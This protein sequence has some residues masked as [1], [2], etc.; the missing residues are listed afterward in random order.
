MDKAIWIIL[1]VLAGAMLPIQAGLNTKVGKEI[2][3]PVWASLIS[4][5]VGAIAL[6]I[7]VAVTKTNI[8]LSGFKTVPAYAWSAGALGAFYV[9]VVIL[10]YPKLGPALTFG[11]IVTGQL[12][13]SLIMDHFNILVHQ[14][15]TINW[16][17][18]FG[19]LLVVAGVVIIRKF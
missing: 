5:V 4:F 10:A 19:M 16:F 9:T 18:I 2:V 12:F 15:H 7:Y 17:R 6:L 13:L 8:Q 11:L 3:S 1:V 14:Q